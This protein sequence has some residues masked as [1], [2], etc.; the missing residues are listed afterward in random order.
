MISLTE[1]EELADSY[2]VIPVVKRLF[3]GIETPIGLYQKLCGEREDTFLLESAEQG[4]W[5]RYSFI[6]VAS[7]G[8]LTADENEA[9]WNSKSSALPSE[10]LATDPI[11]ALKQL[12]SSWESAP[13]DF[14]LS[15]GL[16][17]FVSWGAVNLI[18]RLPAPKNADYEVPL[19]GFNQFSDLVVLDHSKAEML[20]VH[21]IFLD[22]DGSLE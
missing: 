10:E 2:N 21:V 18:E 15:S 3:N 13:V 14:P 7:R 19:Y 17:G 8:T 16:V 4:V 9:T 5:G 11:E 12:Q 6:G 22:S 20:L 1:V